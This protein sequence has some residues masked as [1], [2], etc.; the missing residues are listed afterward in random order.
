MPEPLPNTYV[1]KTPP[2]WA[3]T[4]RQFL[5]TLNDGATYTAIFTFK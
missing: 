3:G 5:V 4:C 1:W 2:A